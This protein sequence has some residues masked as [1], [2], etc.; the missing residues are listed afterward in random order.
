MIIVGIDLSTK[1]VA[2]VVL[3]DQPQSRKSGTRWTAAKVYEIVAEGSK[4]ADRFPDIVGKFNSFVKAQFDGRA[5]V[6]AFI[7]DI[8]FVKGRRTEL[9]LAKV[10][11]ALEAILRVHG[12]G[13]MT[14]NNQT[15]KAAFNLSRSAKNDVVAFVR[16]VAHIGD[17]KLSED[18]ADAAIVALYGRRFLADRAP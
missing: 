9:D 12:V 8:S 16:E 17:Q 4:A 11:G 10:Q 2:V 18:A 6:W 7:E 14:V 3:R 15:V 1:K 5:S 13:V